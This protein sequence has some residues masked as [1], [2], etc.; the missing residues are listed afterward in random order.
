[1]NH[2]MVSCYIMTVIMNDTWLS[3][4][5][6]NTEGAIRKSKTNMTDKPG[7]TQTQDKLNTEQHKKLKTGSTRTP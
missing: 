7:K 1:M 6:E 3:E 5:D 4:I 2:D